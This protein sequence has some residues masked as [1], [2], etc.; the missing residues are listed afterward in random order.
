MRRHKMSL[1]PEE[2]LKNACVGGTSVAD[3]IAFR[4]FDRAPFASG[5][6]WLNRAAFRD[7]AERKIAQYKI[8][9]RSP[10]GDVSRPIG[11]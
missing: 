10:G 9:T 5:G 8:K 1:L 2:P 7:D 3:N 11:L 4:E 6:W